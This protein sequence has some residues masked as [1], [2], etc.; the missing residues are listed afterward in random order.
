VSATSF[1]ERQIVQIR[2]GGRTVLLRKMKVA[3]RFSPTLPLLIMAIPV[4][5][6]SRLIRPW[7]LV[8]WG[9]L[10]SSRIGHFAG[11][12]ELYLCERDA[13][14][15]IPK[16]RHVDLFFMQ[17]P[18][19]NQQ[20]AKMWKRVLHVWPSWTRL[21][22]YLANRLIACGEIHIIGN[23]TQADRDVHNLLNRFPPHLNFTAEETAHG[24]AGLRMMGIPTGAPFVCL[25]VRDSAYL[26]AHTHRDWS[27][28]NYR[29]SNIQNYVLAAEELADRGYF[30]IRMGAK[31]RESMKSKHPKVIDYAT[32]GMRSDFMDVYLGS[33][34][35]FCVA[36]IAGWEEVPLMFRRPVAFVNFV[37]LGYLWT[38]GPQIMGI[39]KHH[40]SLHQEREL[41]LREIF[42]TGAGFYLRTADYE[43]KGIR[44]IE[45]TCQ[46]IR[47]VVV[48]MVERLSGTWQPQEGDEALQR[49]FW[50]TY[51]TDAKTADGKPLHGEICSN[52]G[53]AFLRNNREWLR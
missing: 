2:Q 42:A 52:F 28:H 50:E 11:N 20:L 41:T 44:H 46:E 7:L 40:F 15:N 48:E 9:S 37:P 39:T 16:Q 22:I 6:A 10:H 5:V 51:P 35:E 3:L 21:P 19:C 43:S 12:T 26:D 45:N 27:Y 33:K 4:V 47:D 17:R 29:D 49:K 34:C 18:I 32:N 36:G 24:E 8:R 23:N 38:F 30:V 53:A 13:G 1:I 31:V 25:I 14:I